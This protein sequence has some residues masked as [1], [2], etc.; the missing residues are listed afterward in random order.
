MDGELEFIRE[1]L[2]LFEAALR[3]D[4]TCSFKLADGVCEFE[5]DSWVDFTLNELINKDIVK[6]TITDNVF[7]L[8][9]IK[10]YRQ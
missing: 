3:L 1:C 5:S 7:R 10:R 8:E 6:M 9:H 4:S 2:Y